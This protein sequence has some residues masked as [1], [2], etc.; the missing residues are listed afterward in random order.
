M[1]RWQ[2]DVF[3]V[4][5]DADDVEIQAIFDVEADEVMQSILVELTDDLDHHLASDLDAGRRTPPFVAHHTRDDSGCAIA[6][7]K[8]LEFG[9]VVASADG[10]ERAVSNFDARCRWSSHLGNGVFVNDR[11]GGVNGTGRVEHLHPLL[12][13]VGRR[14]RQVPAHRFAGQSRVNQTAIVQHVGA[15][16]ESSERLEVM[17]HEQ[18]RHSLVLQLAQLRHTARRESR[19]A[20]RERF[21]DDENLGVDVDRNRERQPY[22][23]AARVGLDRQIDELPDFRKGQDAIVSRINLGGAQP[24]QGS[25]EIDVVVPGELRI[26]ARPELEQR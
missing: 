25:V 1:H 6:V 17:T 2:L 26:E 19:V 20:N 13:E 21:I 16:A 23:H 7:A 8:Q 18:D 10:L 14:E 9:Q 3:L 4:S 24:Q 22:E 11:T 12:V 5:V 15:S